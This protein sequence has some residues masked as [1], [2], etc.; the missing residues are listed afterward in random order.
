M[1]PEEIEMFVHTLKNVAQK[2]QTIEQM[3]RGVKKDLDDLAYEIFK[4]KAH[5]EE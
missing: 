4:I 5:K 2:L 1:T 3:Q